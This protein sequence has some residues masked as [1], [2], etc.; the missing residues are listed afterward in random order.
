MSNVPPIR[1]KRANILERLARG[2]SVDVIASAEDT[3]PG[4][5]YN[6][7]SM[8]RREHASSENAS[9]SISTPA[10]EG[11]EIDLHPAGPASAGRVPLESTISSAPP[12][13]GVV[14]ATFPLEASLEDPVSDEMRLNSTR[15][16]NHLAIARQRLTLANQNLQL[17]IEERRVTEELQETQIRRAIFDICPEPRNMFSNQNL[18]TQA[19]L[20]I[21]ENVEPFRTMYFRNVEF[22]INRGVWSHDLTDESMLIACLDQSFALSDT[23][24]LVAHNSRTL[25]RDHVIEFLTRLL[26]PA[27][28]YCPYDHTPVLSCW[29]WGF[30]VKYHVW[31]L[32][33][34]LLIRKFAN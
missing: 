6:V 13:A 29:P 3:S 23:S 22:N 15:T 20:T 28:G 31:S 11:V 12:V 9:P 30:C 26:N 5:I 4:Y 7:R 25:L 1:D 27:G 10:S 8:Q 14:T 17:S 33:D 16:G 18:Y 2:E 19:M 32:S 24:E 34:P 21:L